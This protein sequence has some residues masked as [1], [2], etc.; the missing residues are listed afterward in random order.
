MSQVKQSQSQ[1]EAL[2]ESAPDAVVVVDAEGRIVLVNAQT[3][4]LFGYDRSEL[5]GEPLET[6]LPERLRASHVGHRREYLD[7]PQSRPM[8]I[9]LDLWAR[10]RDGTEVPIDVSLSTVAGDQGPLMSAFVRDITDRKAA[11]TVLHE[12]AERVAMVDDR[13]RIARNL[14]DTVIQRLFATGMTLE[15]TVPL[16]ERPEARARLERAVEDLDETIRAIRTTIF[17]LE[18]RRQAPPSSLRR[19]VL[20]V[21]SEAAASLGFEPAVRFEG[22]VDAAVSDEL[23]AQLLPTL[24]EAV[25]NVVRH[26]KATRL[27]VTLDASDEVVL[28]VVDNGVGVQTS[29]SSTGN[30]LRNLR[31]RAEALGGGLELGTGNP[32]GTVLTWTVPNTG[33]SA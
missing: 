6:L 32:G 19:Q 15:G 31:E 33:R 2:V 8:G 25:S 27:D 7:D 1:H 16:I 22:P 23:T 11:D 28:R 3:E 10:R 13:E 18:A 4:R 29:G 17:E 30:G 14:H 26:A 12:T 24:R 21:V 9:G 5:L 20:E